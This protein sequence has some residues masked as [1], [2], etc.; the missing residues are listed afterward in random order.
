LQ[1]LLTIFSKTKCKNGFTSIIYIFK[2]NKYKIKTKL[3]FFGLWGACVPSC[4]K[5]HI[6]FS[7]DSI[8]L[9]I[10]SQMFYGILP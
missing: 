4:N 7:M 8:T 2:K 10:L 5:F 1:C 6:Y 3:P 9:E